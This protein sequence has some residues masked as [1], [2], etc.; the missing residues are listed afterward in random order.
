M[1]VN[2]GDKIFNPETWEKVNP[3]NR[4]ILDDYVLEMKS[5]GKSKGTIYQYS[6]DIKMFFCWAHD[7]GNKPILDMKKREFRRFFLE[8]K[9]RGTSAARVNRVQCSIRNLLEFCTED[10]DEYEDYEINAMRAIKGLSKEPVREIHFV[11]DEHVRAMVEK[12]VEAGK[13]QRALYLTLSYESCGRRNEMAQVLKHD[14]LENN[15]TNELVGK[16]GKKYKALYFDRAREIAKMYFEQRGEDDI[17]SLWT[18][19]KGETKRPATYD[20]LYQWAVSL[21]KELKKFL[22]NTLKSMLI[23]GATVV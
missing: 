12:L 21:R 3:E 10:D 22:E 4:A 16:R 13:Y 7:N 9:D 15:R 19:G 1:A 6:A 18:V 17:D 5:K 11:K 8:M 14:F 2:K 23:H 20:N